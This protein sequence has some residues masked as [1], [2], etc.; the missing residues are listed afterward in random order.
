MLFG[1]VLWGLTAAVAGTGVGTQF[2]A[3]GARVPGQP[4]SVAASGRWWRLQTDETGLYR[5]RCDDLA[6]AGVD[7]AGLDLRGLRVFAGRPQAAG[8]SVPDAEL[9]VPVRIA[10]NGG[11]CTTPGDGIEFWS[12][13]PLLPNRTTALLGSAASNPL[14]AAGYWLALDAGGGLPMPQLPSADGGTFSPAVS[15]T[16]WWEEN[17]YYRPSVPPP[18]TAPA[19]SSGEIHDHW[20]WDLLTANSGTRSYP[21]ALNAVAPAGENQSAGGTLRLTLAGLAGTHAL[22]VL[23]NDVPLGTLAWD[24]P[25]LFTGEL[26]VPEGVLRAGDNSIKLLFSRKSG[27]VLLDRFGLEY[28]SPLRWTESTATAVLTAQMPAG[29]WRI[30]P[31]AGPQGATTVLDITDRRHP[32][33]IKPL[34]PAGACAQEW[35]LAGAAPRVY[36]FVGEE[37]RRPA[38]LK[39]LAPLT[40]RT[41]HA[42]ADYIVLAPAEFRQEGQRLAALRAAEGLRTVVV[43]VAEVYD[44]FG[45]GS[46]QYGAAAIAAFLA[47]AYA[48][49]Q[50]PAPAYALLLGGSTF[51]SRGYCAE[52][53][54]CPE[55]PAGVAP[56][57]IPPLL[58][59]VDPWLGETAADNRYVAF[60][61][62]SNL[63]CLAIGR[64]PASNAA[65]LRAMV[66]TVI[67]YETAAGSLLETGRTGATAPNLH[68]TLIA[69]NAYTT[70]GV[71]DAGGNFWQ[72]SDAALGAATAA[73]AQAGRTLRADR[74]YLNVCN[75][76]QYPQCTLPN[77]PYRNFP[78]GT[79][80]AA[81]LAA[82]LAADGQHGA[83]NDAHLL[84]YL[85]HGSIQGWAGDPAILRRNDLR[86]LPAGTTLPIV[87]DM[88]CYTG[89]FIYPGLPALAE[90]WLAEGKAAAVVASSGLG[91]ADGHAVLDDA[92][93]RTI[94]GNE[95]PRLGTALLTAK[96]LAAAAGGPREEVDTFTLFGD[97]ALHIYPHTLVLPASPSPP[98]TPTLP[99]DT[100]TPP[101]TAVPTMTCTPTPPALGEQPKNA[102][103]LPWVGAYRASNGQSAGEY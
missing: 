50:P 85:G 76:A 47:Y 41:P 12:E 88:S 87:I 15:Q 48:N 93:L 81:A 18:G 61:P 91:L 84:H 92:L 65:A 34:C 21:F 36:A 40:W 90:S 102:V 54:A 70:Y 35:G 14:D 8:G 24:G 9:E 26:T 17:R 38:R 75:P 27:F 6:A 89:Y 58:A 98:P 74:L 45:A 60:D 53:G 83:Q 44:E 101:A 52:P 59:P 23:V 78:E 37:G 22:E 62:Q 68:M 94:A 56:T 63:P 1:S 28:T 69:D 51:D 42:G 31:T 39:P 80:L 19:A 11:V 7:T 86:G 20:F 5:I 13:A 82:A 16:L 99:A 95:N 72:L 49:W 57:Y 10:A 64:L 67:G 4:A 79:V 43:D 30:A 3:A 32:V 97:P 66:D 73:A 103:Y 96:H 77:P 100:L 46:D 71:R 55:I 25:V 2:E 29:A 33:E